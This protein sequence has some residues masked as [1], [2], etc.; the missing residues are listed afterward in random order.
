[1]KKKLL[2]MIAVV[3]AV[4]MAFTTLATTASA[5]GTV[6]SNRRFKYYVAIGDS[7]PAGHG[8]QGVEDGDPYTL[9]NQ[10]ERTGPNIIKGS[11]PQLVRDAIGADAYKLARE[12]YMTPNILRVIDPAYDKE[13]ARPENYYDRFWTEY[14]YLAAQ[15][16]SYLDD[17]DYL[18]ETAQAAIRKADIITINLGNNDTFSK[19]MM[20]P[21]MRTAYYAFGMN[22]QPALTMIRDQYQPI[23]TEEQ[24][25]EMYG[26]YDEFM[27]LVHKYTEEYKQNYERLI[28]RI[29][30]LNPDCEIYVLGVYNLFGQAEG[31]WLLQEFLEEENKNLINELKRFYT[32]ESKWRNEI[33]YVNVKNTE[34]WETEPMYSPLYYL[35]FLISCHPTFKG[36]QYMANQVIKAINK[37]G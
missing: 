25:L 29:R 27:N 33:T 1:M 34:T 32:K 21:Y 3:M 5:A 20:D 16:T 26:S 35:H 24:F 2:R 13:I 11:Y 22:I 30:K 36:H 4:L 37:N 14:C 10:M 7:I 6:K 8:L 19:A 23:E 18:R 9:D 31:G 17:T 12:M 15:G 28:K